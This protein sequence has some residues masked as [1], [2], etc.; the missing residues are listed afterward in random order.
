M[1]QQ[2]NLYLAEFRKQ[3]DW[4]DLNSMLSLIGVLL[5]VLLAVTGFE[6]WK[7]STLESE[8]KISQQNRAILAAETQQL[9]D[10]Y[11]VQSEDPEIRAGIIGLEEELSGK[12]I[13][14]SF[15]DGRDIGATDG[16]SGYLA[17]LARYHLAGLRLTSVEL[18]SG[19]NEI[20]LDGEVLAAELVPL[21]LQSLRRG[22]SF[23][24]KEF[25]MIR[26]SENEEFDSDSEFRIFNVA[27][28]NND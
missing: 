15:L 5:I 12:E 26:I 16:F 11:G 21:Y 9:I 1:N 23:R 19:G 8:L 22:P 3:K 20:N 4:L 2:I 24:G 25:E 28:T 10:S 14:L 13:L 17:D 7:V 27:T 18:G 6:F